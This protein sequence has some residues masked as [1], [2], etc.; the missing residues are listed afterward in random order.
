MIHCAL[1]RRFGLLVLLF[2]LL[3]SAVSFWG[4]PVAFSAP[5][6]PG[7]SNRYQA[8]SWSDSSMPVA[9]GVQL[10]TFQSETGR[11]PVRG[12]ILTVEV[13][14]P[15]IGVRLLTPGPLA[16][17]QP[18]SQLTAQAGAVAAINGDFFDIYHTNAPYGAAI[19]DGQLLKGPI[20]SWTRAAG[21]GQDGLGRIADLNLGG[22]VR[23]PFGEVPLG[24]LNAHNIPAGGIGAYT[25][26]WGPS[27]RGRAVE[28][29]LGVHEVTVQN[30]VVVGKADFAGGGWIAPDALVLL[31]REDGAA[32]LAALNIG[33]V[34]SAVY[35]PATDAPVPFQIAIGGKTVL[36]RDGQIQDVPDNESEPRTAIGFSADGQRMYLVT[37]DG[38]QRASRGLTLR[39]MGGLMLQVGAD[40]A[41]NLDG[42]G[43]TTMLARKPGD[44]GAQVVNR[45][46]NGRERAVPNGIGIITAPGSGQ[47][48][49]LRVFPVLGEDYNRVFPGLSR[50]LAAKGFDENYGPAAYSSLDWESVAPEQGNFEP[51]GVFRAGQPGTAWVIAHGTGA[52]G[53]KQS[54]GYPVVVLSYLARIAAT[55]A[56]MTLNAG[57][58]PG[59]FGVTGYAEDGQ[60]A[61]I[62]AR[63][64]ALAYDQSVVT[65]TPVNEQVFQITPNVAH[66]AT[67]VVMSVG[68]HTTLF[69][70]FVGLQNIVVTEFD[71]LAAWT[72]AGTDAEGGLVLAPGQNSQGL[73]MQYN[74]SQ[75]SINR[76]ATAL[77]NPPLTLPGEVLRVGLWVHGY[78]Q[79]EQ[80]IFNLRDAA[81]APL[82]ITG[83]RVAWS[84]WQYVEVDLPAG[85]AYPVQLVGLTAREADPTRLYSGQLL[86]D[87]LGVKSA[88]R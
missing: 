39:E 42:G 16:A 9:P 41:L 76:S 11:G 4:A 8:F 66:G 50:T 17:A 86:F 3:L 6:A 83:P 5:G 53:R 56:G 31:G 84:G 48:Q 23:L 65:I 12:T 71:D 58:E 57:A 24:A 73:L 55:A 22:V 64:M 40:D 29:A 49:G 44:A 2:V 74:F 19:A 79:G 59:Y 52:A 47:L 51:G 60:S 26:A 77:A 10:T 78:G 70:V 87:G 33:D 72:F 67:T 1:R 20:W 45:P 28:G 81:G 14:N 85:V 21:I 69:P 68:G 27:G 80:L 75:P 62:E 36:L 35:W 30:G 63:D 18:L 54:D 46:S 43:S 32:A 7:K 88:L 61:S 38:R 37:V 13:G 82:D 25:T 34:A 15:R